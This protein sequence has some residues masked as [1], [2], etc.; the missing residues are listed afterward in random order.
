MGQHVVDSRILSMMS[1]PLIMAIKTSM[2]FWITRSLIEE[3]DDLVRSLNENSKLV[4][5][6]LEHMIQDHRLSL[7]QSFW[8]EQAR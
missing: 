4:I 2:L 8:G 1:L 3:E 6:T 5:L 7:F